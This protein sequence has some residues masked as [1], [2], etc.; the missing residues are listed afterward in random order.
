LAVTGITA[1]NKVYDGT[2]DATINTTGATLMG[3][4][5]GDAVT[6]V[7]SGATGTF[8]TK[9]V[10]TGKTVTVSGLALT[11]ADAGNYVI[12]PPTTTANITAATLTVSGLTANDK[13]YDG[14]TLATFDTSTAALVGVASSDHVA[15]DT[16]NLTGT[17]ATKDVGAGQAVTV[18]GLG[19]TGTDAGNYL[20]TTPAPTASI[21][22]AV[23]TVTG[24]T[25]S[26]K[27]YDGTTV[28]TLVISSPALVGVVSGEDVTLNSTSAKGAFSTKDVGTGLA[29]TVSGL[30]LSGADAG[31]YVLTAP[32]PTANITPAAL[33]VSGLAANNKVYDGTLDTTL[34]TN[35]A[36]L[37]G[38]VSGDAVNLG[39]ANAVGIFATKAVGVN[40]EVAVLGLALTGADAGNYTLFAPIL[41]ATITAAPL[42]VTG[43]TAANKAFDGTTA[44]TLNT[45]GASLV[46]AVA[47]DAVTLVVAAA[48]GTFDTPDVGTGKTVF[49]TGLTLN[50]ADSGN[51]AL[52]Q[53]TTTASIT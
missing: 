42:T 22:P 36:T 51:Y 33:T 32:M 12:T 7:T 44:A 46:G 35:S 21:A 25:A 3:V 41:S 37:M 45:T 2:T 14:T 20:L 24:L 17:F 10:G 28:A 38:V 27:V 19:L 47:G 39:T 4:L 23:L 52:T 5:S 6:L 48:V 34:V 26:D 50:G 49:I 30:L 43:I 9:D 16:T 29:V 40:K 31:N 18:S 53:P 1:D 15:L 11:G 13:P 8:A